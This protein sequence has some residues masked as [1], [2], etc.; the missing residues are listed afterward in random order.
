MAANTM[1]PPMAE[2]RAIHH[3]LQ[4]MLSTLNRMEIEFEEAIVVPL[5]FLQSFLV[6][7]TAMLGLSKGAFGSYDDELVQTPFWKVMAV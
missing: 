4:G 6:F 2:T 7:L 1:M 3:M 5:I